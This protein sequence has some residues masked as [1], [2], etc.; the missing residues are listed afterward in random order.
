VNLLFFPMY[1]PKHE[2]AN[3]PIY[4]KKA[5]KWFFLMLWCT[6]L[7]ILFWKTKYSGPMLKGI[8]CLLHRKQWSEVGFYIV[9]E[10]RLI[11]LCFASDIENKLCVTFSESRILNGT[12]FI[13]ITL[14]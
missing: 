5:V 4:L 3:C 10:E 9:L 12:M 8:F 11:L 13:I 2:T 7:D 14:Y 6:S 1:I